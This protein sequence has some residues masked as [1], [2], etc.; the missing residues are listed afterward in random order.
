MKTTFLSV[1]RTYQ[2]DYRKNKSFIHFLF[3]CKPVEHEWL[4]EPENQTVTQGSTVS[5]TCDVTNLGE[6]DVMVWTSRNPDMT[7]FFNQHKIDGA[8]GHYS[9]ES[10]DNG[11]TLVISGAQVRDSG[12]FECDVRGWQARS[13]TLLVVGKSTLIDTI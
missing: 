2:H 10:R 4:V 12:D 3:L 13:M 8:P 11:Y 5:I 9:V 1:T 7:L 6:D